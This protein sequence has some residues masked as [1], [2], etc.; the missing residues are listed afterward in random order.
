MKY[1]KPE[2]RDGQPYSPDYDDVYFSADN[3][4]EETEHVFIQHNQLKQR[5]NE[6]DSLG[7]RF[8]IAETGFGSG[9]NFLITARHWLAQ[10]SPE[11]CLYFYSVES[12][13]FSPE[14]LCQAHK[15]W[16]EL[17]TVAEELQ[18]QYQLASYGFHRFDL[19]QG[20]IK[21]V[22]MV[23]D[24]ELML[25]QM[26]AS[27]DAWFLDGFAPSLNQQMWS[28][29]VFSQIKRLSH[30]ASTFSTYTAVGDVRRGLMSVGF[31]V[32]KVSGW[33]NKRH[34]LSGVFSEN[35]SFKAHSNQPWYEVKYR[36]LK[37]KTACVIGAGIAG[38]TV[39]WSLV[40]RGYQ[41]EVIEAGDRPG[42]QASGNP[43]AMIMP[44]LNLQDSAD[45]EFYTS[46]YFYALRCLNQLD[47]NQECWQ[48]SG[49]LQLSSSERIKKQ[50]EE[51]PQDKALA[52]AMSAAQ[53]SQLCGLSINEPVH[54]YPLAA[55]L[56][57]EK[58]L[59][60]LIEDMGDALKIRYNC[61]VEK[62]NYTDQQW[63]IENRQGE[64]ISRVDCLIMSSA[65]QTRDFKQFSHLDI[66]PAR[67]QLSLLKSN[68]QSQPLSMPLSFKGYILPENDNVHVLGASFKAEN[69]TNE[70]I[71]NEHQSNLLDLQAWFKNLFNAEDIVGGRASV[72]AVAGDRTP[73]V[74]PAPSEQAYLSA[75]ADLNKGKPANKYPIADNLPNLYVSTAHGARG[76]TSAFLSAELLCAYICNEPLPVSN[77]VRYAVHPARFLIR[78][79]KKNRGQ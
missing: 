40:K 61:K 42:A 19:F 58:L 11:D 38:L 12:T 25:P 68:K 48:Q 50:I 21:L 55:C 53:A 30:K 4:I 62:L 2:W 76:F 66:Q 3:G 35:I 29:A 13:P 65:W 49:G 79:L 39:A 72:R 1:A 32:K 78:T 7:G 27:V 59:N 17:K 74:G 69:S 33:G 71:D 51:Y 60:K 14:D 63:H 34:M 67:G 75:Y 28:E 56:Y 46:A 64:L 15:A 47:N 41:V 9:L 6:L 57:P 24:V 52:V 5:F 43:R 10:S 77:R 70:L 8:V 20:R 54:F 44:R 22:L 73:I 18:Q 16:P 26:Q 36:P 31:E 23:G 45:A 37:H